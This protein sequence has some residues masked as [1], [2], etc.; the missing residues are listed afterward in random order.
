MYHL[1]GML[2][3]REAEHGGGGVSVPPFQFCCEP[4]MALKIKCVKHNQK[5]KRNEAVTSPHRALH[6]YGPFSHFLLLRLSYIWAHC[7][8]SIN[9][10]DWMQ[11]LS[12]EMVRTW[13]FHFLI[14]SGWNLD[15]KNWITVSGLCFKIG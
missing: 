6:I 4:T 3:R 8:C 7:I 9:N 2:I 15:S 11:Q 1:V 14:C 12:W 13:N 5:I 10:A